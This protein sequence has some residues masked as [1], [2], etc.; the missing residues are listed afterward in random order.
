VS[1]F[2]EKIKAMGRFR[3]VV[4][5]FLVAAP[6]SLREWW[7]KAAPRLRRITRWAL[8]ALMIILIGAALHLKDLHEPVPGSVETSSLV[9]GSSVRLSGIAVQ[10]RIEVTFGDLLI[11]EKEG[12][13]S[14]GGIAGGSFLV[15][16]PMR[17]GGCRR[18]VR[19][20]GGGCSGATGKL[21]T[22]ESLRV[23]VLRPDVSLRVGIQAEDLQALS[24]VHGA[25]TLEQDVPSGWTLEEDGRLTILSFECDAATP[26]MITVLASR[27]TKRRIQCARHAGT[28]RLRVPHLERSS[29]PLFVNDV[30]L[31]MIEDLSAREAALSAEDGIARVERSGIPLSPGPKSVKILAAD[32]RQLRFEFESG[33]DKER[34]LLSVRTDAAKSF[35]VSH[36]E[37]VPN[38]FE[39]HEVLALIILS[40]ILTLTPL[41]WKVF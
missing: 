26:L 38:W 10:P 41:L 23:R 13:S 7:K 1:G 2:R 15:E 12:V 24:L 3:A 8:L 17:L 31:F 30:D 40:V 33:G 19:R 11:E 4:W 35:Q 6:V 36:A 18:L 28:Y 5:T 20:I 14:A 16:L 9:P 22:F 37:E 34:E 21:R 25:R 32:G 39:R 29:L 27:S